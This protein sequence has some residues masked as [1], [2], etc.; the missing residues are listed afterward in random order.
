[1]KISPLLKSVELVGGQVKLAAEIRIWH[2]QNGTVVKV[3]QAH[4]WNW[5]NSESPTPPAEHCRAIEEIT[6][7]AVTRYEL[8]PDVFGASADRES[9]QTQEAA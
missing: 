6:N 4:V 1:M 5:L 7:G 9:N 8:R 2:A 3:A